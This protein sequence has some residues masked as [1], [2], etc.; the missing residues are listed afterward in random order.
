LSIE[1]K[2]NW[3]GSISAATFPDR[4]RPIFSSHKSQE[5]IIK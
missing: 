4:E 3:L 1:L 5:I 2:L